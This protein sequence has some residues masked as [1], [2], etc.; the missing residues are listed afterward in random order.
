MSAFRSQTRKTAGDFNSSESLEFV[1]LEKMTVSLAI[2]VGEGLYNPT[3]TIIIY[4][5]QTKKEGFARFRN[6][7]NTTSVM[8]APLNKM[9]KKG[10]FF[11]HS[12]TYSIVIV[13]RTSS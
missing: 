2:T 5:I 7:K 13:V 4:Y 10:L 11:L 8:S 9:K 12:R 6:E 1:D 3:Q